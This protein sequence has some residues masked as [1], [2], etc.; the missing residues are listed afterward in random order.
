MLTLAETGLGCRRQ[1]RDA[2]SLQ[3]I[4]QVNRAPTGMV[5]TK[6]QDAR[7][8]ATFDLRRRRRWFRRS[9]LQ[10]LEATFFVALQPGVHTLATH[11]E[12]VSHFR[13]RKTISNDA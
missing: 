13:D 9:F 6:L 10:C 12:L 5:T 3:L 4:L 2:F 7:F 11:A 8:N 1:W